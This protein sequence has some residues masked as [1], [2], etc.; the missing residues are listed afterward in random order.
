[1]RQG[2]KSLSNVSILL[3]IDIFFSPYNY[4]LRVIFMNN[5][6]HLY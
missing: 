6:R 3:D 4:L 1:M 2:K 5:I